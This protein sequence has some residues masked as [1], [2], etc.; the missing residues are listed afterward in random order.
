MNKQKR[1]WD[2]NGK[3]VFDEM[4]KQV[5]KPL[6]IAKLYFDFRDLPPK[7]KYNQHFA[8]IINDDKEQPIKLPYYFDMD[9]D[10]ITNKNELL[11]IRIFNWMPSD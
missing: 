8:I 2:V 9:N 5:I 6:Q 10:R 7:M 1:N 11:V 3:G 4:H